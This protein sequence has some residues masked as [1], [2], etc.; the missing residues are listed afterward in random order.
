MPNGLVIIGWRE[1]ICL[2]DLEA[3]P[4]KAKTDR[5]SGGN[6]SPRSLKNE[7]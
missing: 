5:L 2:P 4:I 6:M 1:W 7:A 3:A